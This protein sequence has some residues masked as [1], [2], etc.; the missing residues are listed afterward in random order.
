M[1][2]VIINIPLARR[3]SQQAT[4]R[5][6]RTILREIR[7]SARL[8][9]SHGPYTTGRLAGSIEI[10]GPYPGLGEVRGSVGSDKPYAEAV[11]SGSGLYGPR[12][13]KYTIRPHPPKR[14]LRFFWRKMGRTV[15]LERVR[16]PGQQGKHYLTDALRE[17]ARRHNLRVIIRE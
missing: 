17:V 1:A 6:V 4:M 12:A 15:F 16:H 14:Y 11:N 10:D 3:T 7:L 2:R 13:S 8:K 9:V 5:Y